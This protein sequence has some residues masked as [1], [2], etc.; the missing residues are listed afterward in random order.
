[1]AICDKLQVFGFNKIIRI[2]KIKQSQFRF[3]DPLINGQYP[4]VMQDIVKDRLPSFTPEQAK[5]VKGSSDYFGINQYTAYHISDQ[6]TPQQAPTSYSSDW[7][8]SY[9]FQRN[10]VTIGHLA[11]SNWLYMVLTGM[12]GV[13][14]YLKEWI[15]LETSHARSSC[16][17]QQGSSSTRTTSLS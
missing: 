4:K 17:T 1:M 3:L 15:N 8:V 2:D 6:Q 14:N 11:N 13:V 7:G 12:Y 16:M 10:G 5:L 9:N